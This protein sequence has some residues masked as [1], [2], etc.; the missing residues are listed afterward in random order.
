MLSLLRFTSHAMLI[1]VG[2]KSIKNIENLNNVALPN[3][4]VGSCDGTW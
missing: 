1:S 3:T 2:M 4:V